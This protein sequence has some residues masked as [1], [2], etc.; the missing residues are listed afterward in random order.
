MLLCILRDALP[1]HSIGLTLCFNPSYRSDNE[2]LS[3]TIHEALLV[4]LGRGA[5]N[6]VRVIVCDISRIFEH[7]LKEKIRQQIIDIFRSTR[8]ANVEA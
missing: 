4:I 6:C 8:A 7:Q 1:T 3:Y 5:I 2:L